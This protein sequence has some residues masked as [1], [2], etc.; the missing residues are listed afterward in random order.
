MPNFTDRAA[1]EGARL[2][3]DGYL[4][5]TVKC[6]R[7]GCQDYAAAELGLTDRQ[8]SITVYRPESAVFA[9]DS[10]A[11]YAGK[12]VTVNHPPVMVDSTNWKEY[13]AGEVGGEIARDGEFVV[14]P[15]KL[16]DAA[17]I[18]A[19]QDGTR[20]ISMGY[21]TPLEMA[22]GVAPD[23][24]PYQ[25]VQTGPIK[26]NHLAIVPKARGGSE[27]RIGDS[28]DKWGVSPLI[29][30]ADTK[31]SQMAD[32]LQTVVLGD[33]AAQVAVAD[34]PKIEAFKAAMAKKLSDAEK[35]MSEKEDEYAEKMAAKDAE[36]AKKDAAIAAL[37]DA[38]LSDADLDAKV[39]ARADLIGKAKAVADGIETTG[40]ADADI[41]K[42][43]VA[44]ALGD[45]AVEG[46]TQAYIDARFDILVEDAEKRDPAQKMKDSQRQTVTG[47]DAVYQERNTALESAWKTK[48]AA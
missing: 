33:Q 30:T 39:S 41:R 27:L 35:K 48:G 32:T 31:G 6:A 23:G 4:V 46:K 11:T 13:A 18:Q 10:L 37:E 47:L 40:K 15:M 8:G 7:T 12:P 44:K 5:A 16:M 26:I 9:K 19:V 43:A 34:A 36:I 2:T 1:L 3:G 45:A 38:K 14:V 29:T 20:E 42:A 24:T 28:A 17:A 25:A 22:D 21:T